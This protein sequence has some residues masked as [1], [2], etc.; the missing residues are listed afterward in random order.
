MT[1]WVLPSYKCYN[2]LSK[3]WMVLLLNIIYCVAFSNSAVMASACL[4][5][6]S[7]FVFLSFSLHSLLKYLN[8]RYCTMMLLIEGVVKTLMT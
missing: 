3:D 4:S 7:H 8:F 1:A 5:L 6:Q 2:I